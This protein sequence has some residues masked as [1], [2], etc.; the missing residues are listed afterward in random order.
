MDKKW[1]DIVFV[2]KEHRGNFKNIS[3]LLNH[4]I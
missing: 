3:K 2:F 1:K 4:R